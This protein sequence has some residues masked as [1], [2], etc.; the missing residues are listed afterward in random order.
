MNSLSNS[1][2]KQRFALVRAAD[3]ISLLYD[4]GRNSAA[5]DADSVP[6]FSGGQTRRSAITEPDQEG[7]APAVDIELMGRW[8][9][10]LTFSLTA[11]QSP[12]RIVNAVQLLTAHGEIVPY[13][14]DT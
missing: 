8:G 3:A 10:R 11:Y 7:Y 5:H 6:T 13:L 2:S 1:S 12:A 9:V 14:P 4:S